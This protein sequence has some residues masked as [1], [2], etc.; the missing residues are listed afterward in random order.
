MLSN[1]KVRILGCAHSLNDIYIGSQVFDLSILSQTKFVSLRLFQLA[2]PSVNQVG[3]FVNI[4]ILLIIFV[5][6]GFQHLKKKT[7]LRQ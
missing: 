3:W 1:L 4:T 5:E 7:K 6:Y 2:L